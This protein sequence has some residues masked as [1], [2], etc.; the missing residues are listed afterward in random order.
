MYLVVFRSRK[1]AGYDAEAYARH[2]DAMEELARAQ[3]GKIG[4]PAERNPAPH[5]HHAAQRRPH[6]G[7]GYSQIS[8]EDH[9]EQRNRQPGQNEAIGKPG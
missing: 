1:R 6:P 5:H 3:P 8:P 2:A 7:R 9:Y 4:A